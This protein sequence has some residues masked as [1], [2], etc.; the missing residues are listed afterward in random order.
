MTESSRTRDPADALS[1]VLRKVEAVVFDTDGVITDSVRVHAAAWQTAFDAFLRDH[2]P[3]DP[4]HRRP[5]DPRDDYLRYVDGK[6]RVDGATA[7]LAAR[8]YDPPPE[9]VLAVAAH[10]ERLFTERLREHGIDAYPGTVRLLHALRRAAVPMAAA[11]ASRHARELLTRAGVLHL[12]DALVDG[13]EAARLGLPGKP[14][15]DLFLEAARRLGVPAD[16]AAV[17][18]DALAGVEAGRQGGFALVVGVDRAT[19]KESAARL[20]R[21][22]ADIVVRDLGELLVRGAPA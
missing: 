21:Q 1:P 8:G 11:S 16:R 20:L 19:G 13:G 5:F 2:P 6:S 9:Q 4:R 18:E 7:F 3:A 14:R 10:K 17:V 12:F 22:G 15:P